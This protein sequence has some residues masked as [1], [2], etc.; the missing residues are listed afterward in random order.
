[1]PRHKL[2]HTITIDAAAP[3]QAGFTLDEDSAPQLVASIAANTANQAHSLS[4]IKNAIVDLFLVSDQQLTIKTNSI[5]SPG[6][7]ITL[8]A[9]RPLIWNS[10]DGYFS[11]PISN[12]LTTLYV[13][14]N[15]TVAAT[16]RAYLLT[17]ST[18]LS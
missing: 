6:Q 17:D 5:N 18:I 15:T 4:V 3:V 9:S 7:T 2:T 13:T 8:K 16:L 10:E 14:N 1:M 12:N 11:C